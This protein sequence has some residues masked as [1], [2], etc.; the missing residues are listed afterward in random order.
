M[1]KGQSLSTKVEAS[2]VNP[3]KQGYI[4]HSDDTSASKSQVYNLS[5]L[6]KYRAGVTTKEAYSSEESIL[7]QDD[8]KHGITVSQTG[9]VDSHQMADRV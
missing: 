5:R 7:P 1:I 8:G 9:R 3:S 6:D 2:G 4:N